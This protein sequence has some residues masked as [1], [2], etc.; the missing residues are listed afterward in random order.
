MLVTSIKSFCPLVILELELQEPQ[1]PRPSAKGYCN[2]VLLN[3]TDI[4]VRKLTVYTEV[5]DQYY[6]LLYG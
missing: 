1:E 4:N 2:D 6:I 5:N 3:T